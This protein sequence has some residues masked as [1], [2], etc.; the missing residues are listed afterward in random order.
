MASFHQPPS[1]PRPIS[2]PGFKSIDASILIEEESI[3]NYKARRYYPARIG[4]VLNARYQLVGKLGY[5]SSSTVWLCRDL[6]EHRYVALKV[7]V[8]SSKTHRE[9]PIYERL[10]RI[11]TKHPGRRC[12][13][14]LLDSFEIAGPHGRHCCLVHQPLGMSLHDLKLRARDRVFSKDVLRSSVRQLLAALDYLHNEAHVIHTD[15]QPNNLLMGV[16]DESIFSDYEKEELEH[17][18]PRKIIIGDDRIIY[19]SRPLSLT[20]GPPVLC[21]LGEARLGD[22]EH[23]DDIMP[24]VYRAPEV[25]LGMKWSYQVDIWSV[26][27][28][29]WDLFE[30]RHLFQGRNPDEKYDDGYHLA[31]MVA[32]LGPP[33]LEF[34]KRSENCLRYWDENGNWRGLV[35]IP[36]LNFEQLERRLEGEDKHG[37]LRFMKKML[38]WIPEERPTAGELIFDPWLMEGLFDP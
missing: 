19:L 10:K 22:E 35:P 4:E 16:D 1:E 25:I 37:F 30:Y 11:Q 38:R 33:P 21:D 34:L 24:D 18:V 9:L 29:V 8:N 12:L 15:L 6:L 2:S 32:V 5:S 31:D 13:R 20:F 26:A 3:P 7:Y 28:V 36:D 17:P 23:D 14:M 27:M